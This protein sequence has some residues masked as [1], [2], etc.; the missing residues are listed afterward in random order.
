MKRSHLVALLLIAFLAGLFLRGCFSPTPKTALAD[1]AAHAVAEDTIWTCSMHPQIRQPHPGKCPLCGMDLTPLHSGSNKQLGPRQIELSP[2]ARAIAQIETAPVERR[3]VE[4][5]IRMV[6]KIAFDST[7]ARDVTVLA[8][9]VI[10]RLFV[11]YEGVPL[12]KGDHL[13]EIY[14]PE[15]LAAQKE[16]LAAQRSGNAEGARQ[17]LSLLGVLDEEIDATLQRGTASR[18]FTVRSPVD[19]VLVSKNGNEGH[20]LNRGDT[21]AT[22]TDNT[23]VWALLDAYESD[24]GSIHYGQLVELTVEALPGRTFTGHVAFIPPELNDQT[25]SA[26]IRLNVPN[27]DG[28]LKP[29][30]FVR[31]TLLARQSVSGKEVS[32]ELAD[33]WICPMHPEVIKAAPGTCDICD[34]ALVPTLELG[35]VSAD[36]VTSIPPLVIPA[37]APLLTGRRAIVYVADPHSPGLYEGREVELGPRAG[38]FYIVKEGL[39]EGEQVVVRG[40]MKID[41]AAQLLAKPSMMSPVETAEENAAELEPY[42][43]SFNALLHAYLDLAG[44]LANDDLDGAHANAAQL[45]EAAKADFPRIATHATTLVAAKSLDTARIAFGLISQPV[46]AIA[47]EHAAD[48]RERA[49]IAFCP[50]AN[51]DKGAEWLQRTE[52]IL[53]PYFGDE[54]LTC[55]VIRGHVGAEN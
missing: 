8:D 24:L 7:R 3:F 16:L 5:E 47:R 2:A 39:R 35:F 27:P 51:D 49:F 28:S 26:K 33:K 41:S 4:S 53:N 9:G 43:E 15:V 48:L 45:Q 18:T 30:M 54:M 6:G 20:W 44:A 46:V 10:E 12:R 11:N 22:I 21:L 17:K 19:G 32:P 29:G 40:N 23:A 55:G 52:A 42:A 34:M 13:A 25:R 31:A 14:S 50:M 37:T 38:N 36:A 1:E